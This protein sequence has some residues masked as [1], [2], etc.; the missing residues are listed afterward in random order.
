MNSY[1]LEEAESD[2]WNIKCTNLTTLEFHPLWNSIGEAAEGTGFPPWPCSEQFVSVKITLWVVATCII[3][4]KSRHVT[5]SLMRTVVGDWKV[6]YVFF[7][8]SL[9]WAFASHHWHLPFALS[10]NCGLANPT[11][12]I[13]CSIGP[14][15]E[16]L[17]SMACGPWSVY[18]SNN[19]LMIDSWIPNWDY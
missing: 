3:L 14:T 10:N 18:N 8:C 5:Q 4:Q 16:L 13:W 2:L 19:Y 15:G 7:T 11:Q 1:M 6:W 9:H 17:L 12:W